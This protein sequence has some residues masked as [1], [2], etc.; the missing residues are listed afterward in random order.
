MPELTGTAVLLLVAGFVFAFT[1]GWADAVRSI[2]TAVSTRVWSPVQ[3]V[4]L[5]GVSN[6]LGALFGSEV[7]RVVGLSILPPGPDASPAVLAALFAGL[8]WVAAATASGFPVSSSH[9]LLGGLVGAGLAR[10]GWGVLA[11]KGVKLVL[12]AA[13][14]GPLG[15]GLGGWALLAFVRALLGGQPV[16]LVHRWLRHLQAL[17]AAALY[18]GHGT[19]DGQ[20][21]MGVLALGLGAAPVLA[22]SEV[23]A[24]VRLTVALAL[25][26]GTAVGGWAVARSRGVR[27]LHLDPPSGFATET[28]S[29]ALLLLA[30]ATGAPVSAT[31]AVTGA[32]LGVGAAGRTGIVRWGLA[33]PVLWVWAVTL[34][35]AAAV[36]YA[37]S[38]LLAVLP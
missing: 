22:R 34:P 6:A 8:L 7:A 25:G 23:P 18:A 31:H 29:A 33:G 30:A 26:L 14:L 13:V 36:G 38:R 32:I 11:T 5:A 4:L 37:L 15:A 35:G 3:A 1:N 24:H 16:G 10:F 20:K 19:S 28:S 2:S 9:A 27:I 12:A 21:V 17:S